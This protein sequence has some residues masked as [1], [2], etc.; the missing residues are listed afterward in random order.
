M[1]DGAG[2]RAGE[3]LRGSV[4]PDFLE[5]ELIYENREIVR[6]E[7]P[8]EAPGFPKVTARQ[9]SRGELLVLRNGQLS[10]TRNC[11]VVDRWIDLKSILFMIATPLTAVVDLVVTPVYWIWKSLL[12]MH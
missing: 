6:V 11:P 3:V 10:W 2:Y 9:V 1:W 5:T 7:F 4:A 12:P 8:L